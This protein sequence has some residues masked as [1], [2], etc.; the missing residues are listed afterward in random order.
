MVELPA[1]VGEPVGPGNAVIKIEPP[2]RNLRLSELLDVIVK[3][4][5]QPIEYSIE[6]YG[7]VFS[8]K[9]A[10]NASLYTRA[11]PFDTAWLERDH[12][13]STDDPAGLRAALRRM[14][15]A[16]GLSFDPPSQVFYSANRGQLLVRAPLEELDRVAILIER[17]KT[18]TS[19][20]LPS[21]DAAA[22]TGSP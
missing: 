18:N 10:G 22:R 3:V 21:A 11:F 7:I 9:S 14:F 5:D 16:G 13:V 15:E 1:P 12:G 17:L 8:K 4:A 2:L 6:D 19:P 20:S